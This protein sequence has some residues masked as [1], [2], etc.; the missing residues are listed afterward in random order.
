MGFFSWM[1]AD[2][3]RSIM[4][5]HSHYPTETV[6]MLSPNGGAPIQEDAYGGYGVFGGVDA[7][8]HLA[9]TNLPAEML[10]GRDDEYVRMAGCALEGGYYEL[11]EDGTKHQICHE[12]AEII[13]PAITFHAVT[14]DRPIE[15]FGGRS[16]NEMI[17]AK[18]LVERRFHIEHPLKFAHDPKAV[19]E[20]LPASR[21]C[22]CQGFFG[23][24]EEED[25]A[26]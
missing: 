13:D 25:E 17:A 19:Y 18:L 22:P 24:G 1:T 14:Y 20:D 21:D 4:N 5:V 7:Y 10:A 6:H 12:G 2:T 8:V 3:G 11:V 16:A 23:R 26:A 15:A 9:R